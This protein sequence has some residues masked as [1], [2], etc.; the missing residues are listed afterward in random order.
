MK[1]L[2]EL[3]R[4]IPE[5]GWHA[6]RDMEIMAVVNDSRKAA[7][8]SLFIAVRGAETDGHRFIGKA[9]EKGAAAVIAEEAPKEDIPY[10]LVPDTRIAE[11]LIAE[12]FYDYPSKSLSMIGITGTNGK[13]TTT[14][15]VKH[16]LDSVSTAPVGLIG[17]IENRIGDRVIPT[18]RTTPDAIEL[19]KLLSEMVEAGCRYAVMEVSSHALDLHRVYGIR[20][21]VSAFTNL[22]EDHL[23]YHKT[24]EAY[25]EAKAILFASQSDQAIINADDPW[26]SYME[27]SANC[28]VAKLSTKDKGADFFAED[29]QFSAA[30]VSYLLKT[31]EGT[32]PVHLAIPGRFSIYNS[33]TAIALCV[34][35]GFSTAAC[36]Q[37]IGTAHGVKGRMEVYPADGDYT[38]LIDYAHSPDAI[39]NVLQATR[40]VTDGRLVILFGCGGDRDRAKRP[41]MGRIAAKLADFV[42]V[43]SD[44]PRTED[45]EAIIDDILPGLQEYPTP[46]ERITDRIE[47]IHYAVDHH[48]P[49]DVIIL[50]GKGHETYQEVNHVKHDMDERV[51]LSEYFK[52]RALQ[53]NR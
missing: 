32:F 50:A 46:Y 12:A 13:T 47:A 28:P 20:Y 51:I 33:M 1:T 11:A 5:A 24:M 7:K 38:I 29:L 49:G 31:E 43:T 25:A 22:T 2:E 30:G 52:Q 4:E 9:M 40:E 36:V 15:L 14:F 48:Q 44:N 23:D 21:A 39:E 45:P 16:I 35:L 19:Q 6:P 26:A 18:E 27:K 10:I 37:A 8:G 42:I 34:K 41:I 3:L 53:Q 17:T